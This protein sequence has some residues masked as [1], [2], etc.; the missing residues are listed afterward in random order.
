MSPCHHYHLPPGLV[1]TPD[2][3]TFKKLLYSQIHHCVST[4]HSS[5]L[6]FQG[7]GSAIKYNGMCGQFFK[8]MLIYTCCMDNVSQMN[9]VVRALH[10]KSIPGI[11]GMFDSEEEGSV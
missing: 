5:S 1:Q 11:Y 3:K 8:K 10:T 7:K 2:L 6:S 4:D 9:A